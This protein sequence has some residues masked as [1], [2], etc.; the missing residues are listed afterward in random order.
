[1]QGSGRQSEPSGGISAFRGG[2]SN[3]EGE[4]VDYGVPTDKFV[5][6]DAVSDMVSHDNARL[7]V[8]KNSNEDLHVMYDR[9]MGTKTS[10]AGGGGDSPDHLPIQQ[11]QSDMRHRRGNLS[12]SMDEKVSLGN[13]QN[14]MEEP[15]YSGGTLIYNPTINQQIRNR[16]I[17]RDERG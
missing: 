5:V 7:A 16:H 9:V 15:A 6:A 4:T 10:I 12:V 13:S 17:I 1:M 8:S 3:D 2:V 14:N 11:H